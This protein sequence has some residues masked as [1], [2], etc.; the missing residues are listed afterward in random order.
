[1]ILGTAPYM[2]P[3]QA[4]GNPVDRRTDIWA[5]GC[6]LYEML[7][8][9]QAFPIGE[10]TS[11]TLAGVLARDPDWTAL[12]ADTP[13]RLA[14]LI[15]RCLRKDPRERLRDIGDALHE[16]ETASM[17]VAPAPSSSISKQHREWAWA[18][19]AIVAVAI[20]AALAIAPWRSP[21][22]SA[23]VAFT[24]EAPLGATIDVG[25]PLSPDGRK[26]AFVA[27]SSNGKPMLWIRALDSLTA[28]ALEGTE[29]ASSPFWSPDSGHLGF[30]ATGSLKRIPVAGGAVQTICSVDQPIGGSWGSTGVIVFGGRG[31]ISSVP[32]AGGSPSPVTTVNVSAGEQ[33]HTTPD[34]LPDGR[35]FLYTVLSGGLAISQTYVT[36]LD[37]SDRQPLP[38]IGSAARYAPTGH[39]LFYRR[40][41]LMAQPFELEGFALSGEPFPVAAA[42]AETQVPS[43]SVSANGSLAYLAARDTDTELRWF[44]RAGTDL[45]LAAPRGSFLNPEMSPD[46]TRVAVDR[47]NGAGIDIY[48]VTLSTGANPVTSRS[49]RITFDES[50]D[51]T[52]LWAP[53]GDRIAFTSYRRGRGRVY[54]RVIDAVGDDTLVQETDHEQRAGDWSADGRWIAYVEESEDGQGTAD[55]WAVSLD[56]ARTKVRVTNT[57]FEE[58]L[59]QLSP[60]ARW[61]TYEHWGPAGIETYVQ[62]FPGPGAREQVSISGGRGARWSHDGKELFYVAPDGTVMAVP[63]A[64]SGNTIKLGEPTRLF[65]APVA[66]TAGLGRVLNVTADGR[67]LLNVEPADRARPSIVVLHDWA[68]SLTR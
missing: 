10:T 26:L 6:I 8:G 35:H 59:P 62:A 14:A 65:R 17:V 47:D 51:Y 39:L 43:A 53:S 19:V 48:T 4:R 44:D 2:S 55:V 16:L 60:D 3:E 20:A 29:D 25:Q 56:A 37:S 58:N 5:F 68:Q 54:E 40:Q 38:G 18:A 45:G 15:E 27:P 11:D 67:F 57:P 50:A 32:A 52:P 24:V 31:A 61:I 22:P 36:S 34:F 41:T 63:V 1:V 23:S 49:N 42:A 9:R 13:P 7:S 30:F 12:P 64:A 21:A 46:E 33:W 66:F 28:Q